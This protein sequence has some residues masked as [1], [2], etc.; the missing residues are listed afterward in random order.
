MMVETRCKIAQNVSFN[1]KIKYFS[2]EEFVY[3]S[4][5]CLANAQW[6]EAEPNPVRA[7]RMISHWLNMSLTQE[8]PTTFLLPVYF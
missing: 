7:D 4:S 6:H 5:W 1:K 3:G 2:F 8:P